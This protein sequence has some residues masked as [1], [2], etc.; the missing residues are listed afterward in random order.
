LANGEDQ[1]QPCKRIGITDPCYAQR[2]KKRQYYRG[3]RH[4]HN[5]KYEVTAMYGMGDGQSCYTFCQQ[6][7]QELCGQKDSSTPK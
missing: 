1:E 2:R 3:L 4:G 7:S 6:P 5:G